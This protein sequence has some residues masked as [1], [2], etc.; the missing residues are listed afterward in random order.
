MKLRKEEEKKDGILVQSNGGGRRK[1]EEEE[2]EKEESKKGEEGKTVVVGIKM[3]AESRELLTWALVK[4]AS[5]GDRVLALHVLPSSAA[6]VSHHN[7]NSPSS[8]L[9]LVKAFDSMLAVYEGFCNLKQIDLKLKLSRGSSIRKD[10]V[11]EVNSSAASKLILGITKNNRSFG[12]SSSTSIAKYCAKKL[13][14]DC[15]VLAVN[16]GKIVFRREPLPASQSTANNS[17]GDHVRSS[18]SALV[19]WQESKNYS[20]R[21]NR[22]DDKL[23]IKSQAGRNTNTSS[24]LLPCLPVVSKRRLSCVSLGADNVLPSLDDTK[25]QNSGVCSPVS[26]PL[27][28]ELEKDESLAL[29]PG[30]KPEAPS[31]SVSHLIKDSPQARPGWPLLRKSV[32]P[33]QKTT[34]AER[35]KTS[36][37]QW[38]MRLPSRHSAVSTVHPDQKPAKL[39]ANAT[40]GV[41]GKRGAI[42]PFETDSC[43]PSPTIDNG[44]KKIPKELES[45]REKYSSVCRLFSYKELVQLTS[46]FS[47]EKFIGRGGSSH[48]YRCCLSD[49]KELAVKILKPSEHILNEFVSEIEIITALNHKN[50]ISLFGFCFENDNLILVYDYLSRGSLEESL[51]GESEN[52]NVLGWVERY[53]VAVGIAEALD[54]LHGA[55]NVQPVI[56]RDVKSSNI[57]L[58]GDFEPKLSDFGLAKW[59]SA[60]TVDFSCNDVAGTFGYL[61][62]EYFMYGKVNEKTDVYAFGVV[63]LELISGR[64]P[65]CTGCPKGQESL[66]IWAK[67]ILQDGKV[68][69]LVD[70]C[71]GTNYSDDQLERMI[72][73]ASLCIRRAPRCRPR[74]ATVLKLLGGDDDILKWAK[75]QVSASKEFDGLDDEAPLQDSNIQSYINLALLDDDSLSVSSVDPAVDFIAANTSLEEYLRGRWSRS[76]SFN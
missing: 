62:P 59:A 56:H 45:L 28:S 9:S 30:K 33:N 58:S 75:S 35:S 22:G 19:P 65:V 10:L 15:S 25:R 72:L 46:N 64:K 8:L 31:S 70:P 20:K 74:I 66:V 21:S 23:A 44:E 73:A 27:C 52:K 76:S 13:S 5:P 41:D 54:Y 48:V 47:P 61:A 26:L 11:R 32:L 53:K 3:D 7:E 18:S 34:S 49:G 4:V 60:S 36:V 51:H 63:L 2:E 55:A 38:A 17:V 1:E 6:D 24:T 50:I 14:R 67:K 29:V 12:R 40:S 37:V 39:E 43:S 68:K 57:L 71:L 69:Q 42:V 16:N